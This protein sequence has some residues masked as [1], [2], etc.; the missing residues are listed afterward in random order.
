M[1][2]ISAQVHSF[3]A[4]DLIEFNRI[5]QPTLRSTNVLYSLYSLTNDTVTKEIHLLDLLDS[6]TCQLTQN[7]KDHSPYWINDH[8]ALF[9][10]SRSGLNQ[11]W[12][13]DIQSKE[14]N[15]VSF[16]PL[17]IE[18][19]KVK[20]GVVLFTAEVYIKGSGTM[21]E[22]F[23]LNTEQKLRKNDGVVYGI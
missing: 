17:S 9:L 6:S 20:S 13:L 18:N 2:T 10:S 15:Q 7:S 4:Q 12:S 11:I 5:S 8:T 22:A 3:T 1:T 23:K 14:I 16:Y 19:L 21:E